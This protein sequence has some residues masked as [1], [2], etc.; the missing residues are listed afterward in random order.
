MFL[1]L[2]WLG[3]ALALMPLLIQPDDS[4]QQRY[5]PS[6]PLDINQTTFPFD[7]EATTS[8]GMVLVKCPDVKYRH[9]N[10]NES[11]VPNSDVLKPESVF[12]PNTNFLAW[13]PLLR[14]ESGPT[15][16]KCGEIIL[17]YNTNPYND[18]TYNVHWND[19]IIDDIPRDLLHMKTVLPTPSAQCDYDPDKILKISSNKENSMTEQIKGANIEKP[20]VNQMVYYFKKPSGAGKDTIKKPCFIYKIFGDCPIF[21]LINRQENNIANEVKKIKIDNLNGQKEEI[22]VNL[23]LGTNEDFYRG[24]KIS[25]SKLRYLE[26]GI[27]PIEDSTTSIT[28]SFDINGFDLVQLTYT[29]VEGSGITNVTQKYYFGPKFNDSTFDKTEEISANDTSIKV[30]CDNTYLNVGYLKEIEYNGIHAGVKDLNSTDSMR[31]K[32]SKGGSSISFVESNNGTTVIS[33]IYKTLDGSITTTTKFINKDKIAGTDIN[34]K[35]V[36]KDKIVLIS[37]STTISPNK[38]KKEVKDEE[39][40]S[41]RRSRTLIGAFMLFLLLLPQ[42]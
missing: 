30:K 16:L 40:N 18:W 2:Y 13:V 6:I 19:S 25:L 41:I 37:S 28:S 9:K 31:G 26:S 23:K 10:K 7:L 8:S 33:C 24:E 1:K 14:I 27:T 15:K 35:Q 39:N 21:D 11:F 3:A 17:K 4:Y 22:K 20:Y 42:L 34:E 32:F 38:V 29:C 36:A 12:S 5:F